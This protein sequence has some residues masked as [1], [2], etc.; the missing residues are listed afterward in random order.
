MLGCQDGNGEQRK[1]PPQGPE[2]LAW[3]GTGDRRSQA[4]A[5][6]VG[7][8]TSLQEVLH[9][10]APSLWGEKGSGA[11]S[12]DPRPLRVPPLDFMH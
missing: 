9:R 1:Q 4:L 6:L 12:A 8:H 2:K 11:D 5:Y 10:A 3:L 7:T